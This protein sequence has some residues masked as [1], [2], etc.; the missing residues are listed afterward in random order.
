M[1]DPINS[2]PF[3]TIIEIFSRL[4]TPDLAI[5]TSIS[6]DWRRRLLT[7]PEINRVIDLEGLDE[8]MDQDEMIALIHRLCSNSAPS[9]RGPL[10]EIKINVNRFWEQ[11]EK[12]L[13]ST[14]ERTDL[15]SLMKAT[16]Y[17][18][19]VLVCAISLATKGKL[20]KISFNVDRGLVGGFD[21]A[22]N[23]D[24]L[25]VQSAQI[26][27]SC[28]PDNQLREIRFCVPFPIEVKARGKLCHFSVEDSSDDCCS[29]YNSISCKRFLQDLVKLTSG[30]L[31]KLKLDTDSFQDLGFG[32]G[33]EN[34]L[35]EL[36]QEIENS[37]DSLE[38]INLAFRSSNLPDQ[39][40]N[41]VTSCPKL[42]VLS[43]RYLAG[44][45]FFPLGTV[46]SAPSFDLKHLTLSVLHSYETE[47]MD[48]L[49]SWVGP[50]LESFSFSLIG[51]TEL[52]QLKATT[53]AS[54]L[55]TSSSLKHLE[56]GT[57]TLI[58]FV[59]STFNQ[60]LPNLQSLDLDR[61][62]LS[63]YQFISSLSMPTL[64][65]LDFGVAVSGD[66][67]FGGLVEPEEGA[68]VGL[69][70]LEILR[71]Y[72]SSLKKL[73]INTTMSIFE[74]MEENKELIL[75]SQLEQ[76]GIWN[77][78]FGLEF[79]SGFAFPQLRKLSIDSNSVSIDII[80][81]LLDSTSVTLEEIRMRRVK[82]ESSTRP[83]S[84]KFE[85]E[86]EEKEKRKKGRGMGKAMI[87]D[88]LRAVSY[89]WSVD[90]MRFLSLTPALSLLKSTFYLPR[91]IEMRRRALQ[92]VSLSTPDLRLLQA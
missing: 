28:P 39:L 66:R 63:G 45:S 30:G 25:L 89:E 11:F 37:T 91:D 40:F 51:R 88:T 13:S 44:A 16:D 15:T 35:E 77:V 87:D 67:S 14:E 17:K 9:S 2:F 52:S 3:E 7:D 26:L 21:Q 84:L 57:M 53:L 68:Q 24:G 60:L 55:Q 18:F 43:L 32:F 74:S 92:R 1:V 10:K 54:I 79:F 8:W 4:S 34:E 27:L 59:P 76:L 83:A 6:R 5:S 38:E 49:A 50:R 82:I 62:S 56:L 31:I 19:F 90:S 23:T 69:C 85:D 86:M 12:Y 33:E 78:P 20:G 73:R 41:L 65:A 81:T 80:S 48:W 71:K 42:S 64:Q 46:E 75:L 61:L 47:E 22:G 70:F 58:N 72:A 36:Y 29:H